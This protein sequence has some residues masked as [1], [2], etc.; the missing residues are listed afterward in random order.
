M[1]STPPV[2]TVLCMYFWKSC[3]TYLTPAKSIVDD[4]CIWLGRTTSSLLICVRYNCCA[5]HSLNIS[6][7]ILSC[8]M[9]IWIVTWWLSQRLCTILN[10]VRILSSMFITS[11]SAEIPLVW[12][13]ELCM[14]FYR[15]HSSLLCFFSH[16][17]MISVSQT[18]LTPYY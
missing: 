17:L 12:Y 10:S 6:L 9:C 16:I 3:I 5:I 11:C 15:Y 7:Y 13:H 1:V 2:V 4:T 14:F 18:K 8:A